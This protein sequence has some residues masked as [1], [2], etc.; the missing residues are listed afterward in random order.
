MIN[1]DLHTK[2]GVN[3]TIAILLRHKFLP[4]IYAPSK[5]APDGYNYFATY[6][7][8]D[9]DT[10]EYT[11]YI[12]LYIKSGTKD[13]EKYFFTT[14][15][16]PRITH[17]AYEIHYSTIAKNNTNAIKK[18]ELFYVANYKR[19]S[20]I[21]FEN[22][23]VK[24]L[25]DTLI[26]DTLDEAYSVLLPTEWWREWNYLSELYYTSNATTRCHIYLA[27]RT[28]ITTWT[29]Y[30]SNYWNITRER[31]ITS[32]N[33]GTYY[34]MFEEIFDRSVQI[35]GSNSSGVYN[36]YMNIYDIWSDYDPEDEKARQKKKEIM[37]KIN[38]LK[39]QRGMN[40][41]KA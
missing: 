7:Y 5:Y 1:F 2:D 13:T 14:R 41:E 12:D 17:T 8:F 27:Y 4:S 30:I 32:S 6:Y 26:D 36:T 19:R 24:E 18:V 16:D 40:G 33:I 39:E 37:K 29:N 25:F 15:L 10:E 22:D 34:Y 9:Y 21:S 28:D 20:D 35:R 11:T 31:R 23:D 3:N 38:K